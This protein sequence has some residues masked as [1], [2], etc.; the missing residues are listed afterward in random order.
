MR[1]QAKAN[2]WKD[3]K[4]VNLFLP[5]FEGMEQEQIAAYAKSL[6]DDGRLQHA[7]RS[8]EAN[9]KSGTLTSILLAEQ[10]PVGRVVFAGLGKAED[11]DLRTVRRVTTSLIKWAVI[12]EIEQLQLLLLKPA[13]SPLSDAV[14]WHAQ[15]V[16][17]M[18]AAYRYN[19]FKSDPKAVALKSLTLLTTDSKLLPAMRRQLQRALAFGDAVNL[20]RELAL[21]PGNVATPAFLA[22]TAR[23]F[24]RNG[25]KVKVLDAT[26]LAVEKCGGILAVGQGSGQK[27]RMI[28]MEYN[29][30]RKQ[31]ATVALVGKGVTF[32]SGGISLKPGAGMDEMKSD[33]AG[34]AAVLGLFSV[35][36]RLQ[37]Q[38]NV[39]GVVPAAENMPDGLSYRPGDIIRCCS[40]KTVEIL[41]TDAEG[42]L[43]LADGLSWVE[44]KYKPSAIVDV[45][46]LTGAVVVALGHEFSGLLSNNNELAA[47]LLASGAEEGDPAWQLPLTP[48]YEEMVKSDIADLRNSVPGR[49]AGTITAAAFLKAHLRGTPWAHLDI[50]GTSWPKNKKT[51][52]GPQGAAVRLL[53]NLLEN[54]AVPTQ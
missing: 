52:S 40:G 6:Q 20:A 38:V 14:V 42:R 36:H 2:L 15:V 29:C 47:Q 31:A 49:A 1:I 54:F 9:G 33:M 45:A 30:G 39:V 18:M 44:K 24:S 23:R 35:L 3:I 25:I 13:K 4:T 48:E 28:V 22:T 26:R 19:E 43:L 10:S 50:A 11:Y 37:L 51:V 17:S 53:L 21:K 32:D 41:N 5:L 27:P 8:R 7:W 46:T 12:K 34:A 16:A